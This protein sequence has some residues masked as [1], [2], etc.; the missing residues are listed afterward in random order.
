MSTM[1]NKIWVNVIFVLFF[2]AG[3]LC[4]VLAVLELYRP[5]WPQTLGST[6]LCLPSAGVKGM[7]HHCP[8]TPS[9]TAQALIGGKKNREAAI[10][11]TNYIWLHFLLQLN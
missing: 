4:V 2:Q 1:V 11:P 9:F 8:V 5:G 3:F 10:I 6:C 7:H